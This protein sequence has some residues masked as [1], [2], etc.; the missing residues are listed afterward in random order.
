MKKR[1]FTAY[2]RIRRPKGG[3]LSGVEFVAGEAEGFGYGWIDNAPFD[4][5]EALLQGFV[6]QAGLAPSLVGEPEG[7]GE[8]GVGQ[9][10]GRRMLATA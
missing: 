1:I 2:L 9:R 4:D 3:F 10:E 5:V 7:V 6:F 8:G